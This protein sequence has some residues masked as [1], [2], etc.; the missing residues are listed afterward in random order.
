MITSFYL[1]G[2]ETLIFEASTNLN[3]RKSTEPLIE[4]IQS[5]AN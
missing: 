4:K 5:K 1:F 2:P 3:L